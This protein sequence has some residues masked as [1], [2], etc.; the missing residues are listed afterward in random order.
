LREIASGDGVEA[1]RSFVKHS[2]AK[3][4]LGYL[5]NPKDLVL[6]DFID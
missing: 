2:S 6:E 5:G 3:V 4:T 1:A